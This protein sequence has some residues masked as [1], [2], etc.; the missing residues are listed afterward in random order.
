MV[1][2]LALQGMG[3][4][5]KVVRPGLWSH[6]R[7]CWKSRQLLW[8]LS[9]STHDCHSSPYIQAQL[10]TDHT[11]SHCPSLVLPPTVAQA[12]EDH[13]DGPVHSE[14]GKS[15]RAEPPHQGTLGAARRGKGGRESELLDEGE[16]ADRVGISCPGLVRCGNSVT[17]VGRLGAPSPCACWDPSP[18]HR[19]K[20]LMSELGVTACFYISVNF[21]ADIPP[22]SPAHPAETAPPLRHGRATQH[23]N[24]PS[25]PQRPVLNMIPSSTIVLYLLVV[26]I[27]PFPAYPCAPPKAS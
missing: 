2:V 20:C 19:G 10:G 13:G 15:G 4:S 11:G 6:H 1:K 23:W 12:L 26:H 16:F 8:L 25:S 5:G 18:N 3:T 27:C 17:T 24:R 22:A 21:L 9:P 7:E 14:V